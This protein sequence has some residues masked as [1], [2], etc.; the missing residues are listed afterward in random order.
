M[1]LY[2]FIHYSNTNTNSYN[3]IISFAQRVYTFKQVLPI[4]VLNSDSFLF[5]FRK[6]CLHISKK[7]F[8]SVSDLLP[9]DSILHFWSARRYIEEYYCTLVNKFKLVIHL[10]DNY[11]L[12]SQCSSNNCFSESDSLF[13]IRKFKYITSINKNLS[14]LYS[15]PKSKFFLL[16][17]PTIIHNR[18]TY[19]KNSNILHLGTINQYNR[20]QIYDFIKTNLNSFI[21]VGKNFYPEFFNDFKNCYNYGF[22]NEKE[23]NEILSNTLI[24]FVP[25]LARDFDYYRYPSKV[26]DLLSAGVPTLLPDYE[27]YQDIFN[28]F[29]ELKY[30]RPQ[31]DRPIESLAELIEKARCESYRKKLS[32]FAKDYFANQKSFLEFLSIVR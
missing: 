16:R 2:F 25:Y 22:V 23:L 13:I 29:P 12:L 14:T 31:K 21:L 30:N 10:E 1:R 3:H 26:P 20:D 6:G 8:L 15:I 32:Q 24:S 4:I 7:I 28:E 17:P 27:Y 11:N 9:K 5:Y 18:C 19:N